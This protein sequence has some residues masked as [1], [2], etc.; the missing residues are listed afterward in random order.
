MA[1]QVVWA[2][3]SDNSNFNARYSPSGISP[4]ICLQSSALAAPLYEA[5]AAAIGG[6]RWNMDRGASL[7]RVLS[8]PGRGIFNTQA[9]SMLMRVQIPV[10]GLYG[11]FE[12]NS[13]SSFSA[14]RFTLYWAT[15]DWR[16]FVCQENGLAGLSN[17]TIL[18]SAPTTGAYIDIVVTWDGTTASNAFKLWVNG[19]NVAS[20]TCGQA[21]QASK[22]ANL[23]DFI[24]IGGISGVTT[25]RQYFNECV[26]WNYVINPTSVALVSG[27]GSLNGASRNSFVDVAAYDGTTNTDPG[28]AN[29]RLAQAY[30][31]QGVP[32][33]G[34]AAIP[35][36]NNV[37][38]GVATGAT[39]GNIILPTTAQVKNGVPFDSSGGSTGTLNSTD[40]GQTNVKNGV[41]Y[42]IESVA[43]TGSLV[44]TDP[45]IA[46]VS[47]GTD[48]VIENVALEGTR[49]NVTNEFISAELEGQSTEATLEEAV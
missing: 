43:K 37:R 46:N 41:N 33:I 2:A 18:T 13:A 26:I 32:L 3:R 29:V 17:F 16:L 5:D 23:T 11:I 6:F 45:G 28:V 9:I 31:I 10:A 39:V 21:W 35:V 14:N 1:N 27:T 25:V 20:T 47:R 40:P 22:N 34:T 30:T 4:G 12:L 15:N 44:S 19:V 49:D 8:Y 7:S 42:E 38:N 36:A 24:A 48:Y